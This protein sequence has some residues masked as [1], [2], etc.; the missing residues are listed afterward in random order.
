MLTRLALS[1]DPTLGNA[2][3]LALFQVG[4]GDDIF[5]Q[6][7]LDGYDIGV[8]EAGL[9]NVNAKITG[10][11]LNLVF[12]MIKFVARVVATYSSRASSSRSVVVVADLC[13]IR[14]VSTPATYT[15]CHS[16]PLDA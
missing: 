8:D 5:G 1:V 4:G 10:F 13:G 15:L 11:F 16:R 9:F 12:A 7:P 6:D 14:L 3:A 2:V